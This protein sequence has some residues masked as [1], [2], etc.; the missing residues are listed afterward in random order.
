[1]LKHH[2]DSLQIMTDYFRKDPD[3]IAFI[4]GGSVA[5]GEARPDSDLDGMLIVTDQ[6]Y[7]H[8]QQ[9]GTL[10][11]CIEGLCTYPEG[12]F[13]VKYFNKDYLK[14]AA[15][16]GSDP[17]RN[18]FVK[19]QVIFSD[20]PDIAGLVEKIPVFPVD[21]K[22]QR[23]KLF[24]SVLKFS[25]GY[26]YNDALKSGDQY[27]LDKCCFEIVYAGLRMLY[28]YNE[29][30]FPSHKRFLEYAERLRHKPNNII[31]MAKAVNTQ[32]DP[33]SVKAF[34]DAI[35]GFTNWDIAPGS[36]VA[37]Y[38]ENLEQTWQFSDANLY[39]L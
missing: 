24:H 9:S 11:E 15:E 14:A 34:A 22:Q 39:E 16:K 10:A 8:R 6:A 2:A 37:T 33:A 35:L 25:S 20:D 23:I 5:K 19:A 21:K 29:A 12:Y 3:V 7:A 36:H 26:F 31:A 32:K 27:M 17:T 38:V 30:L 1:M 4:F 28:A 18:S 13:D